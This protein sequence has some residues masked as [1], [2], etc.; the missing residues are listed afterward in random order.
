MGYVWAWGHPEH[1]PGTLCS[2]LLPSSSII[3]MQLFGG[4]AAGQRPE[5]LLPAQ[6]RGAARAGTGE[7]DHDK[8]EAVEH[9]DDE[10]G[11]TSKPC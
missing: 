7:L 9:L 6:C 11:G 5:V 8:G 3:I 10:A 2:V 1:F 4:H